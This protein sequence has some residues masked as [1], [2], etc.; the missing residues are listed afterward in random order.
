MEV[1][2]LSSVEAEALDLGSHC[3]FIEFVVAV[4]ATQDHGVLAGGVLH[5]LDLAAFLEEELGLMAADVGLSPL[6]HAPH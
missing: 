1:V 3:G 6:V 5:I 2:M 4:E